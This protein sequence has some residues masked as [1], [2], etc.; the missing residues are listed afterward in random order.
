MIFNIP[1]FE[2]NALIMRHAVT[3]RFTGKKT[4]ILL[5]IL[6]FFLPFCLFSLSFLTYKFKFC[7]FV[8]PS[9][10]TY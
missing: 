7:V 10:P 2:Y 3:K 4:F 5:L 6:P 8:F 1:V 9:N